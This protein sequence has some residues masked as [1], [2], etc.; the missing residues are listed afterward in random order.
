MQKTGAFAYSEI[1]ETQMLGI[2]QQLYSLNTPLNMLSNVDDNSERKS[3]KKNYTSPNY[4]REQNA[5]LHRSVSFK[6]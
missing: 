4:V 3:F 6:H 1:L 5:L 2:L